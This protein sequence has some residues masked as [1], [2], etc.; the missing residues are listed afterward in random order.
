M[1]DF[2]EN[3]S[4]LKKKSDLFEVLIEK[5]EKDKKDLHQTLEE[6]KKIFMYSNLKDNAFVKMDA[7]NIIKVWMK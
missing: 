6:K 7:T 1:K 4:L 2:K 5:H 3:A